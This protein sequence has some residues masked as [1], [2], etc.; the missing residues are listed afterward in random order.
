MKQLRADVERIEA[1][2]DVELRQSGQLMEA[3]RYGVLNGGKRLRAHLVYASSRLCGV[4]LNVADFG[5]VAIEMIHAYSLIHDD[6]PAMDDDD[7]RRG[8]PTVHKEWDDATA[9]LAGDVLQSMAFG[10]LTQA[11]IKADLRVELLS[12]LSRAGRGMVEGQ[13]LDLLAETSR[14]P[15]TLEEIRALQ[16]QKTG[17]LMAWSAG[18]GAIVSGR[19]SSELEQYARALGLAFQIHDDVLDIEGSTQELGKT[20]GKDIIAGKAT[21]VSHLGLEGAKNA[22]KMAI[23]EAISAFYQFGEEAQD[24]RELAQFVIS[25]GN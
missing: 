9:I 11:P 10:K 15:L 19:Y 16:N 14:N 24:L 7:L 2:L 12:K 21:F 20:A 6:L 22:A 3:A 5:A 4:E 18:F 13:M 1:L 25:R 8:K 23:D 17:D